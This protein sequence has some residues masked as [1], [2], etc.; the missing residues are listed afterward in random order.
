MDLKNF[1]AIQPIGAVE[2]HGP[3]LPLNVDYKIID[4][5]ISLLVKNL[6]EK[7]KLLFLPTQKLGKSNEHLK[8]PG[9]LSLSTE[10]LKSILMEIG[11]CVSKTGVKKLVLL[12][13][14]GGN[15]SLLDVVSRE[16]RIKYGML[17]F[18]MNWF[19]FGFPDKL[20]TD[21]E[22]QYGIHA[23][24]IE[25]SVMLAL[26][27]QNVNMQKAENFVSE[28][29]KLNKHFKYISINSLAKIAWQAQDLNRM[30]ACGNAK[31]ATSEKGEITVKYV[32]EKLLEVFNEIEKVPISFVS[33]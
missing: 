24:D 23:G 33:N 22:I 8:F 32:C 6:S 13:S 7:N 16:L 30:G 14:H 1:V 12:N 3:H 19:N 26:D 27:P 31:I 4:G 11:H 5:L 9:T 2:Q 17:I 29:S 28:I 15:S 25:T 20:F 18:N 21:K 10:T